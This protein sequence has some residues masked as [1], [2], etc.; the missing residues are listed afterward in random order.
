MTSLGEVADRQTPGAAQ[1][2]RVGAA[3]HGLLRPARAVRA[4]VAPG[5]PLARPGVGHRRQGGREA[6]GADGRPAQRRRPGHARSSKN[7]AIDPRAPRR[8]R[9]RGREGPAQPGRAGLHGARGAAAVRLRPDDV[10]GRST[11]R[12]ATSSRSRSFDQRVRELRRRQDR[13]GRPVAACEVRLSTSARTS[14]ASRPRTSRV[15]G[16]ALDTARDVARR[17][18][19]P[20]RRR[21]AARRRPCRAQGARRERARPVGAGRPASA[22]RRGRRQRDV[23][24]V[25]PPARRRPRPEPARP[26]RAAAA[27]ARLHADLGPAPARRGR[28]AARE[29]AA[30]QLPGSAPGGRRRR[31]SRARRSRSSSSTTCSSHERGRR[32]PRL[33]RREPGARRRRDRARDRRR[34]LPRLQRELGPAVRADDAA[35]GRPR[36]RREPRPRQ[37][38]ARGRLPRRRRL[39]DAAGRAARRQGRRAG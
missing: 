13:Q 37:R 3:A 26:V 24:P 32:E 11:T 27:A 9:L 33:R 17:R 23:P 30:G 21:P 4:G 5:D 22:G 19:D 38:G 39:G 2:R 12:T 10:D 34:R 36:Q 16:P 15:L 8:P 25:T 29:H 1:P 28:R 18:S 7:L 14:P 6:A 31:S 20:A 35:Q